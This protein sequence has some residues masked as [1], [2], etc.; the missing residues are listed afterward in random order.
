MKYKVI[1]TRGMIPFE[2]SGEMIDDFIK[3]HCYAGEIQ[4][5]E[6]LFDES[7]NMC[8]L[9]GLADSGHGYGFHN[10]W[11]EFTIR[12]GETCSFPHSY[13]SIDGPTDWSDDCFEVTFQL[14]KV[15]S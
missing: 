8:G 11:E 2:I 6:Y 13:T 14:V 15:E 10:G 7:G 4:W 3:R 5:R 9:K 12:F 1:G